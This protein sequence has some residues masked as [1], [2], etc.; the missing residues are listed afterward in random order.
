[1][2]LKRYFAGDLEDGKEAA[3]ISPVHNKQVNINKQIEISERE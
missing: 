2:E 3:A 1:M